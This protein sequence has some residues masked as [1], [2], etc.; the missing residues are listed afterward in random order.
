MIGCGLYFKY[1]HINESVKSLKVKKELLLL[2][3]S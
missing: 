1:W 3:L 2:L